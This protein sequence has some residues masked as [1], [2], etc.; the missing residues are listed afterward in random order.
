MQLLYG[1]IWGLLKGKKHGGTQENSDI[2]A[3]CSIVVQ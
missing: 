1:I 2:F 3:G